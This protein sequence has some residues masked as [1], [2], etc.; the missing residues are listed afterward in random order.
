M[1]TPEFDGYKVDHL[2]LLIG[3]NPLPNYVAAKMLLKEHGKPYLVFSERTE[4]PAERLKE[5]L[6]LSDNEMVPLNNNEANAYEIKKRIREKIKEIQRE[7]ISKYP[8]K[9]QFGLNYTGG[10]KAM[11]VHAYQALLTPDDNDSKIQLNPPPIFSYLDSSSLKMLVDHRGNPIP[12]RI[13]K[14]SLELSL[15]KVFKLHGLSLSKPPKIYVT[16]PEVVKV[17]M[18]NHLVWQKW[19]QAQIS[20]EGRKKDEVKRV[21]RQVEIPEIQETSNIPN[22]V[23]TELYFNSGKWQNA[24][25]LRSLSLPIQE[26]P[27]EIISVFDKNNFLDNK[28]HLSVQKIEEAQQQIEDKYRIP[29]PKE[30]R[31]Y[32]CD[33]CKWLEGGWLEDYVLQQLKQIQIECLV[34]IDDIGMSFDFPKSNNVEFEFDVACLRGYQL[35]AISCTSSDDSGLCKSKL[36]EAYYRARQMGGDEARVALVCC[37]P[38]PNDIKKRFMS[39]VNDPKVQVFGSED[40]L[41]LCEKLKTWIQK[42]DA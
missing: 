5:E 23:E 33:I 12:L 25:E 18:E 30:K 3:E 41:D 24:T 15:E 16:L 8:D 39:Q 40:I 14:K 11:A 34:D 35:F 22:I 36:F 4:K 26:L 1:S 32:P 29:K 37:Y 31:E 10:T 27:E 17:I 28:G 42:V 19:C 7:I 38:K 2:F 9:N 20:L 6:G 21:K 13:P